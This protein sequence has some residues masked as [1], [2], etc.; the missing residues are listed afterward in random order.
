[1][2]G[3][4]KLSGLTGDQMVKT[5]GGNITLNNLKGKIGAYTTGGTIE[6]RENRGTI[7][8]QTEGGDINAEHSEGELRLRTTGGNITST[9]VSGSFIARA[10]AGNIRGQFNNI[11]QGISMETSAG[12]LYADLPI[13]VGFDLS[14][15]GSQIVFDNVEAFQGS[16]NV[17]SVEGRIYG[18]GV[19]VRLRASTGT[20]TVKTN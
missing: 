17:R 10:D 12:N 7:F 19:P 1:M 16:K 8:A 20:I 6:I 2:G 13:G 11:G 18:G 3:N 15:T 5:S 14:A 4:I 9:H